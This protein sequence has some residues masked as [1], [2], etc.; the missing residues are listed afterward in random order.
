[1]CL[2]TFSVACCKYF[3]AILFVFAKC[4]APFRDKNL[5]LHCSGATGDRFWCDPVAQ[6]ARTGLSCITKQ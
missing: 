2:L 4:A 1:M 3:A 6:A 5:T